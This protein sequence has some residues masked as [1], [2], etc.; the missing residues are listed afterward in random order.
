M[1]FIW[2]LF[3]MI[4]SLFLLVV[5]VKYYLNKVDILVVKK[6]LDNMYVDNMVIGVVILE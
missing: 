4:L 3:G 2:V 5:I 6:I 1:R